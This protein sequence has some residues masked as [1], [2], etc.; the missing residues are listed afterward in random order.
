[1]DYIKEL[2]EEQREAV[3]TTE[4][5]VRVIA[6]AGSGKTKAL[7][8]RY[9]YLVNDIGISTSNVLCVTFTNRA[10][11]EM[12]LRIRKSIGDN[13]TGFVCTFHG[14]C[15]QLL[16][17]D[18]HTL[19]YPSNFLVMDSE[20]IES[21]LKSV[22]QQ[23]NINSRSYT[24]TMSKKL[25]ADYKYRK[26]PKYIEEEILKMDISELKE[27]YLTSKNIEDKIFYGYLYEQRKCFGLDYDDLILY[28]LYILNNFAE[29]R[30]KWQK[31][32]QYIMV[33][34]FQDV[35]S[36]NYDLVDI[37]SQYHK[38]LFIVGDPDQTIY[39]WRGA[40]V[41]FIL[42]FDKS[43]KDVKTII[44]DK[45]Y[46]STESILNASNS[47]IRKNTQRIEKDLKPMRSGKI[48]VIYSH[49]KTVGEEAK[50]IVLQIQKLIDA[51]HSY[52]DIAI[53]YRAH[54]VSRSIEEAFIKA[55]IP[56][57]LYSGVEFYKRKEIKDILSYLRMLICE[58][59]LSFLRIINEPKRNIGNKRIGILKNY[60]ETKKCTLYNALK[61]NMENPLIADS[62]ADKFVLMIDKYQKIYK[63]MK[64]TDLLMAIMNDSGYEAM[65][66]QSGEDERLDNVAELK[67][68]ITDYENSAGETT[69]LESYLQNISLFTNVDQS[70][71]KDSI[72]M[73]TIHTAK[74]LEFPCVFVSG[75]NEGIFPSKHTDTKAKMEE[76]RRLAYVAYTRA[77]NSLFLSDSEGIN[78]DGSFR[79]PS[80][81]IFNTDK[82][83]ME[84]T[85]ELEQKLVEDASGYIVS[86]EQKIDA[87][88]KPLLEVGKRIKHIAFGEG[89]ILEVNKDTQ[90]YLIQFDGMETP[91]SINIKVKLEEINK[92]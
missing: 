49:N 40:N 35:N 61:Q 45:N 76:E 73:M 5:Y 58:D 67:Q 14:F 32:L 37:L 77:E 22:Y 64:I 48:P 3:T 47:L 78:Y 63:E 86:N 44:M 71:K 81:F 15:V 50:W 26:K 52:H 33:D 2:N 9:I 11:N 4:G 28:A 21:I 79:F 82:M 31:K 13:D 53:L 92:A 74:G 83:Y 54:F 34:E 12:K 90:S 6:G 88:N 8:N 38:N 91:R 70:D 84:Y 68:S 36:T 41:H 7:T 46:R 56:Y 20:D 39:S 1:M 16:R 23:A 69:D 66:R 59:D 72:K 42:D 65:L 75:L 62:D 85:V 57:I 24:F 19:N 43:Y 29:K 55:K 60:S 27:K 89:K 17:E 51:G 80:R 18:I 30:E 87:M 25:I 10:A